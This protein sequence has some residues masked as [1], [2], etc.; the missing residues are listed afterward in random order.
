MY[1][2]IRLFDK[3]ELIIKMAELSHYFRHNKDLANDAYGWTSGIIKSYLGSRAISEEDAQMMEVACKLLPDFL[4][5]L[6]VA[7]AHRDEKDIERLKDIK[8][9]MQLLPTIGQ[10]ATQ[11]TG[12]LHRKAGH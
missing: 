10:N 1:K 12:M 3:L 8:Y 7:F 6:H 2:S 4:D 9:E 5:V 11:K